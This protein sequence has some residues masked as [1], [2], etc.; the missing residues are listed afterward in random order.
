MKAVVD[1][2]VCI[3]CGLC[4]G[5]APDSFRVD[6]GGLAEF[7]AESDDALVQQ[8]IDACPVAAIAREE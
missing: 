1:Q 5:T 6:D 8:A 3:G 2:N 7:F 4:A